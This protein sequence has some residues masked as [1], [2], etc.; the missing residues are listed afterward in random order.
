MAHE[1][2]AVDNFVHDA[3]AA[4]TNLNTL[5]NGQIWRKR[6]KQNAKMPYCLF[7]FQSGQDFQGLGTVRLLT[8]P[9]FF[10]KLIFKGSITSAIDTA[11]DELDDA[12]G[13]VSVAVSGGYVISARRMTILDYEETDADS[14]PIFH[15]G[16]LYRL[17]VSES[18]A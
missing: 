11:L 2:G 7:G 3:L 1:L 4:K 18:G 10:A 14:N 8:R 13:K 5:V 9:L 15:R 16:G 17:E 6:A 12:M